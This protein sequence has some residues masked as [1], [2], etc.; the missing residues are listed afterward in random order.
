M[1]ALLIGCGQ[2]G[3]RLVEAIMKI[4]CATFGLDESSHSRK[5]QFDALIINT[6]EADIKDIG[7]MFIHKENMLVIGGGYS[8]TSGRGAGGDPRLGTQ[9]AIHDIYRIEAAVDQAIDTI[10]LNPDLRTIDAIILVSALGGGSGSGMGPVIARL[11]KDKFGDHY[12]VIGIVTLPAKT[13]G[14][15]NSYNAYL[16]IQ[17]WLKESNFNG[18][19]TIALGG[20]KLNSSD[21]SLKYFSKF[22]KS[23]AK[24]LYIL[25]GG[26]TMGEGSKTV[27]VN[28]IL[29]TIN[30]GG[31]IC[32]LGHTSCTLTNPESTKNGSECPILTLDA[33]AG[34]VA[35]S[36]VDELLKKINDTCRSNLFLPDID[37]KKTRAALLVV[38]DSK[39]FSLSADAGSKA[40]NYV[41]NMILGNLRFSGLS[42]KNFPLITD[43]SNVRVFS[44][45]EISDSDPAFSRNETVEIALLLAG[46][47][48]VKIIHELEEMA[49][50]VIRFTR[51]PRGE[52]LLAE[53]MGIS[54]GEKLE[55]RLLLPCSDRRDNHEAQIQSKATHAALDQFVSDIYT[56]NRELVAEDRI[57][58]GIRITDVKPV[59][60]IIT[61]SADHNVNTI[62]DCFEIDLAFTNPTDETVLKRKIVVR[63]QKH[64]DSEDN[65]NDKKTIWAPPQFLQNMPDWSAKERRVI[66]EV[67]A[68]AQ[69]Q[70]QD[71]T[72]CGIGN[73][74][75]GEGFIRRSLRRVKII[76]TTSSGPGSRMYYWID[77][78]PKS[79]ILTQEDM[80]KIHAS[81]DKKGYEEFSDIYLE[82]TSDI[83]S[84]EKL[85]K[86]L[87]KLGVQP[88]GGSCNDR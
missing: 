61:C 43:N 41:Q 71:G 66:D 1:K 53:I 80:D 44:D 84:T 75:E 29:A 37:I 51:P 48:D 60:E 26:G 63:I 58:K 39:T 42:H 72:L 11:L 5:P 20:K 2:G 33:P 83:P 17:S 88:V 74:P 69:K 54:L 79:L 14:R 25:L 35:G 49:N 55:N 30:D 47:S 7:T 27:D 19:I 10:S 85:E 70:H 34:G 36:M 82:K 4:Q 28:D 32:T 24:A 8:R 16:S 18:I 21:D 13:E 31:G 12:P 23:V 38:K 15:L 45:A 56:L 3:S 62:H 57:K 6:T 65:G 59:P 50:K 78:Y 64:N 68:V 46:I 40:A 9:A 67:M 22:N 73:C 52:H 77:S 87:A 76:A 86:I 81:G